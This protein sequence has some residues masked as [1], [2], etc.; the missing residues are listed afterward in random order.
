MNFVEYKKL[1]E[2]Q[3]SKNKN[4]NKLWQKRSNMSINNRLV[5]E[6]KKRIITSEISS[7]LEQCYLKRRV[8]FFCE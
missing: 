5:S 6:K 4:V 8:V 1:V 2:Y 3:K 7:I